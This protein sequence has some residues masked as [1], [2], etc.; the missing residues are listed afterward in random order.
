MEICNVVKHTRTTICLD[1][2]CHGNHNGCKSVI[3]WF[4]WQPD[5]TFFLYAYHKINMIC[6]LSCDPCG[7]VLWKYLPAEYEDW[8]VSGSVKV[9]PAKLQDNLQ[10]NV[11]FHLYLA[12]RGDLQQNV[13]FL[14]TGLCGNTSSRMWSFTCI[15]LPW[16]TYLPPAKCEAYVYVALC[17][18][19]Q[20]NVGFHF[21]GIS[22]SV[23]V[24]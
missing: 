22:S 5:S 15:W 16:S 4:P 1:F 21:I 9:P 17:E 11:G 10:P 20:Q 12:L 23:G 3:D 8:L 18:Y 13:E 2:C 24:P 14:C 7:D 6:T 19:L